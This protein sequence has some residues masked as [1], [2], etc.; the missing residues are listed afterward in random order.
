MVLGF[1]ATP[2]KPGEPN[3]GCFN[4]KRKNDSK[5]KRDQSKSPPHAKSASGQGN[6]TLPSLTLKKSKKGKKSTE[7]GQ[8]HTPTAIQTTMFQYIHRDDPTHVNQANLPTPAHDDTNNELVPVTPA[9]VQDNLTNIAHQMNTHTTTNQTTNT[10]QL[11]DQSTNLTSN[12]TT[13]STTP[14][15]QHPTTDLLNFSTIANPNTF[16]VTE[17]IKENNDLNN[18]LIQAILNADQ[19]EKRN[20]LEEWKTKSNAHFT[21]TLTRINNFYTDRT[22]TIQ[23]QVDTIGN[24]NQTNP[25]NQNTA[26]LKK[27][28]QSINEIRLKH[29]TNDRHKDMLLCDRT[30]RIHNLPMRASNARNDMIEDINN[31]FNSNETIKSALHDATITPLAR[32]LNDNGIKP[33]AIHFKSNEAKRD[34][35]EHVK[36]KYTGPVRTSAHWPKDLAPK[37]KKM[38]ENLSTYKCPERN[39]DLTD[40]HILIRPTRSC[41]EISV[42]YRKASH[43]QAKWTNL[44]KFQTPLKDETYNSIGVNPP[45]LPSEVD[46]NHYYDSELDQRTQQHA[47]EFLENMEITVMEEEEIVETEDEL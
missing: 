8:G 10:T 18:Q 27:H 4:P 39:I 33:I 16:P 45:R 29:A 25:N 35:E 14:I 36:K 34:F 17:L 2:R 40:A 9:Q 19:T 20:A 11:T 44:C 7:P 24:V 32:D 38:R 1:H 26:L 28:N 12:I 15:D 23:T 46:P 30:A 5:R 21:K 37:I 31:H 13:N 6:G 47:Q 41:R 3:N 22:N 43:T 42:K